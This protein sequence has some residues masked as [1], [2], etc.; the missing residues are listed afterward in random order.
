LRAAVFL[1]NPRESGLLTFEPKNRSWK[2]AGNKYL[3]SGNRLDDSRATA[4]Q[5]NVIKQFNGLAFNCGF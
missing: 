4:E 2:W 1:V 5:L 3:L